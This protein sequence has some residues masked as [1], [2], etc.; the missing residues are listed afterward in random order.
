MQ[1]TNDLN[2][3][4][5]PGLKTDM[6][7]V[8][9]RLE[10]EF[11]RFRAT[12]LGKFRPNWIDGQAD[13][14]GTKYESTSPLDRNLSLGTF[15][16][17]SPAAVHR[18]I[19]AARKASVQWSRSD[20]QSRVEVVRRFIEALVKRKYELAAAAVFEVGKI[21]YDGLAEVEEG[22]DILRFHA[23]EIERNEGYDIQLASAYPQSRSR[24]IVRPYGVFGIIT[25]F[26]YPLA[27]FWNMGVG[28]LVTGNTIVWKP[29]PHAGLTAS[30]LTA[31][32]EEAGFPA[33][34][35]NIVCGGDEVG[36]ALASGGVDGIGFTGSNAV[37]MNL[38][39]QLSADPYRKPV[40]A[41]MGGK[42]PVYVSRSANLDL[43]TTGVMLGAFSL[44]GQRCSACSVAYV[45]RDLHG[46]F[47]E[48]LK[49][50]TADLQTGNSETRRDVFV[51]PL[52]D[53]KAARRFEAAVRDARQADATVTGG[54]R[55]ANEGD[56]YTPAIVDGLPAGH[57]LLWEEQF[58]PLIAVVPF[59]D[60]SDAL[61]A[62]NS[63]PF[64]L[65]AGFY[66]ED[67]SEQSMYLD[68]VQSGTVYVNRPGG[69]STG[70]WPG[71]QT[72]GGWKGSGSTGK[73][74]FSSRYL[75]EFMHEQNVSIG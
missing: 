56:Y 42:N 5:F 12:Q 54:D 27:Q 11:P 20:W 63:V 1:I 64:G 75:L 6:E 50:K 39:R 9:A 68:R 29:S 26:N 10:T 70:A 41:E 71:F 7:V 73:N 22:I 25:P 19:A 18:A 13:D 31:S 61:E 48:E 24:S 21:R 40:I 3:L 35:V 60:L 69:A 57:R 53:A 47:L 16:A 55:A 36:R 49:G 59:D 8:H 15:V 72:F 74:A 45:H 66:G 2:H 51:G 46:S 43:A 33:G 4:T 17:A 37:G 34:S 38:V 32:F 30:L 58:V 44:A 62:G 23:A 65:T 14:D 28:A 67:E 52:I